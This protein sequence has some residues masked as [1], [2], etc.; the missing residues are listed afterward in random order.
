MRSETI[1]RQL[2]TLSIR[3]MYLL[4]L[5][6]KKK[7]SESILKP[8]SMMLGQKSKESQIEVKRSLKPPQLCQYCPNIDH[9][10]GA[11]GNSV[12]RAVITALSAPPAP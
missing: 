6:G 5:G 3:E 2:S 7:N 10:V 12:S 1:S 11:H 8:I 4:Q 9:D